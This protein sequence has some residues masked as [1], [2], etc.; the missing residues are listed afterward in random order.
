[1]MRSKLKH[2]ET[3]DM[4]YILKGYKALSTCD[5]TFGYTSYSYANAL[6]LCFHFVLLL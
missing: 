5:L 1:M 2:F 3:L 4:I 6:V